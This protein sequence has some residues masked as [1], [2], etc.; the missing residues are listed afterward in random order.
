MLNT[1]DPFDACLYCHDPVANFEP[2][3]RGGS[4][5]NMTCRRCGA[6]FNLAIAT[7]VP[8]LGD[9]PLFLGV[10]SP[11]RHTCQYC[12]EPVVDGEAIQ[13]CG[14]GVIHIECLWRMIRG[15]VN[16]QARRCSCYGGAEPPD[17]PGMTRR[18]AAIAAADFGRTRA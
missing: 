8:F 6:R 12:A 16:H 11:P 4:A 15:G 10:L 18:E 1:F 13:H 7:A 17:P 5:Q 3:P 9:R 14:D 2:G